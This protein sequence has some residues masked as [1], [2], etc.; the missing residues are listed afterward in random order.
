MADSWLTNSTNFSSQFNNDT[1]PLTFAV[2]CTANVIG[3]LAI[4]A[5][6][7]FLLALNY[8]KDK[9]SAFYRF[10]R[11]LSFT[12]LMSSLTFVII[13]NWNGVDSKYFILKYLLPYA[14][15]SIPWMF[16]TCYFLTLF[17]L[18]LNQYMAVCKPWQYNQI[19]GGNCVEIG[20]VIVWLLSSLQI[21][22]PLILISAIYFK[23]SQKMSRETIFHINAI[24]IQIWLG[25]FAFFSVL[26]I[27]LNASIFSKI[28]QLKASLK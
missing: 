3:S 14:F 5:N 4:F 1:L 25:I 22:I 27:A 18:T 17:C 23:K 9:T 21:I 6:L 10:L 20:M 24:E 28:K 26:I 16:L 11:N 12:D 7:S 19:L 15:R 2:T 8:L 13:Q